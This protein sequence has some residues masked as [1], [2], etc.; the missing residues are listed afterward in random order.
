MQNSFNVIAKEAEENLEKEENIDSHNDL[1][2]EERIKKTLEEHPVEC[3]D[4]K[5]YF[6]EKKLKKIIKTSF[7][8]GLASF[9]AAGLS[10]MVAA[11]STGTCKNLLDAN[12]YAEAN[13]A[14]RQEIIEDLTGQLS[15]GKISLSQFESK[16]Q[17][18]KDLDKLAYAQ[19][20]LNES[21]LKKYNTAEAAW[22]ASAYAAGAFTGLG[23]VGVTIS[24][25]VQINLTS[26]EHKRNARDARFSRMLGGR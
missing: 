8:C 11:N 7:I 17:N 26:E 25:A 24:G 4:S 19:E 14:Y 10:V 9:A 18:V 5:R 21:D 22:T 23:I 13:T 15:T 3:S 16:V 2:V 12:G 1:S 20:N 6:K